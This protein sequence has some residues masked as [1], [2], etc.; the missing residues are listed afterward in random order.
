MEKEGMASN[1]SMDAVEAVA[2][3]LAKEKKTDDFYIQN[4]KDYKAPILVEKLPPK[5]PLGA[6][7]IA[8]IDEVNNPL[9]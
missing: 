4:S 3:A 5:V 7:E 1:T 6:G 8:T 2:Y 9:Q